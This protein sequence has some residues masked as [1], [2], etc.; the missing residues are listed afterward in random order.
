MS[1]RLGK[2]RLPGLA[3]VS[4]DNRSVAPLPESHVSLLVRLDSRHG[5]SWDRLIRAVGTENQDGFRAYVEFVDDPAWY[6][7]SIDQ[8][9][10]AVPDNGASVLL[11]A[12]QLTLSTDDFPVLVVDLI[13]GRPSFRCIASELWAVENNL[14]LSNMDWEEFATAVDVDGVYRGFE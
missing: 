14:N 2:E 11:A 1:G 7:S 12:D 8:L 9:R 3:G 5:N 10:A 4:G 6:G 13:E